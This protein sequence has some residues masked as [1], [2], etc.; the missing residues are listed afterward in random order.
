MLYSII[1]TL[2]QWTHPMSWNATAFDIC[3]KKKKKKK[4]KTK[5]KNKQT[6]KQTK[7]TNKM[8]YST[9]TPTCTLW[10]ILKSRIFLLKQNKNFKYLK[11]QFCDF[12]TISL[13]EYVNTLKK[14]CGW[15]KYAVT[16]KKMIPALK[17]YFK[18]NPG[19]TR[20]YLSDS[21]TTVHSKIN[22]KNKTFKKE[23]WSS[24]HVT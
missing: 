23:W 17:F 15:K 18:N 8:N 3:K 21:T 22:D 11:T 1:N 20:S 24:L 4:K 19:S 13:K 10:A 5:Q 16:I 14:G 6:S 12:R 9:I 2:T 7:L